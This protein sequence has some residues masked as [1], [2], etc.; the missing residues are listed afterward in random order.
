VHGIDISRLRVAIRSASPASRQT[1]ERM[2]NA[3][4]KVLKRNLREAHRDPFAAPARRRGGSH[5]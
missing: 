4:G 1:L 3:A 5:A 2:G